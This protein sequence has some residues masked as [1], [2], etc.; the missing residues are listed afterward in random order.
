[1]ALQFCVVCGRGSQRPSWNK[2]GNVNAINYVSCD[3]HT[4][5]SIDIA[6]ID[7]GGVP[8]G[9]QAF[10]AQNGKVRKTISEGGE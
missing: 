3:F 4:Q 1:M 8:A 6:V 2:T 5:S 9:V 7:S 10:P